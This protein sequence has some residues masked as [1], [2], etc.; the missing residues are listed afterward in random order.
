[1]QYFSKISFDK[2][3]AQTFPKVVLLNFEKSF[4]AK[5]AQAFLLELLE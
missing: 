4:L 3:G 1:M 5:V 2:N